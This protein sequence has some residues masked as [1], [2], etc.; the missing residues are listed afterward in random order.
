MCCDLYAV[1][2]TRRWGGKEGGGCLIEWTLD[3]PELAGWTGV[4]LNI[5]C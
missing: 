3:F 1:Y 2:T 5:R 4:A